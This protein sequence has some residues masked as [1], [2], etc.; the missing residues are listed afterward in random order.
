[1]FYAVLLHMR[2][3]WAFFYD[4][5]TRDDC[6]VRHF[7]IVEGFSA[8]YGAPW[9]AKPEGSVGLVRH[10]N[11]RLAH[12]SAERWRSE[13]ASMNYYAE[14]FPIL[15]RSV[16]NFEAALPADMVASDVSY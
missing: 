13:Q 9:S 4:D 16:E 14:F 12:M 6:C 1:M 15:L 10:L 7:C 5:P 3:L 11:K 2:V 8:A